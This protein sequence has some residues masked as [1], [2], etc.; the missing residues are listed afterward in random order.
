MTSRRFMAGQML[1]C[2]LVSPHH[3]LRIVIASEQAL[4]RDGLRSLLEAEWPSCLVLDSDVLD[5]MLRAPELLPNLVVLD[6]ASPRFPGRDLLR[7]ITSK[8]PVV[9]L[10]DERQQPDHEALA[11]RGVWRFID[12]RLGA[13]ALLDAVRSLLLGVER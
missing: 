11:A 4:F 13:S 8:A 5:V 10:W 6:L 2:Q 3:N 12:K 1:R 9:V 7:E